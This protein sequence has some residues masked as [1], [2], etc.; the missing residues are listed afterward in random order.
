MDVIEELKEERLARRKAKAIEERLK[1]IKKVKRRRYKALIIFII[2]IVFVGG[3]S[4]MLSFVINNSK[5]SPF[6]QEPEYAETPTPGKPSQQTATSTPQSET[7]NSDEYTATSVANAD[8]SYPKGFVKNSGNKKSLLALKTEDGEAEIVVNKETT[9]LTAK[10]LM[11]AYRDSI[12]N[13]KAVESLASMS[14]YTI[15]LTAEN[16]TY[17]KKSY[18]KDGTELYYEMKYPSDSEKRG[19]YEEYIEYMDSHFISE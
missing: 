16:V 7:E 6:T 17:H 14:G 4:G 18:V 11:G 2:V 13:S 8:F 3:A 12:A 19:E 10:E 5:D 9:S 15:T 1:N